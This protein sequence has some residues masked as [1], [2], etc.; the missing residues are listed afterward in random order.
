MIADFLQS[1]IDLVSLVVQVQVPLF[2][3]DLQKS[4]KKFLESSTNGPTPDI[5]IQDVFSLYRRTKV[6]LSMFKAFCSQ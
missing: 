3:A 4:A 1:R 6:L 2:I 5:P